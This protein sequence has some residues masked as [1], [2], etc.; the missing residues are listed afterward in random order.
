[1]HRQTINRREAMKRLFVW[2]A[3]A[4]VGGNLLAACDPAVLPTACGPSYDD[5]AIGWGPSVVAP[6][7]YGYADYNP[8]VGAPANMRVYYPSLDGAVQCAPFLAG[9]GHFPLVLFLHGH[10]PSESY[11]YTKWSDLPIVLARSGFIV[12]IPDLTGI[13]NPWELSNPLYALINNVIDWMRSTWSHREFMMEAP[14]LGIVGHSWGTLLG[15]QLALTLPATAYVSL[16]GGWSDWAPLSS[17]P[18]HSL[19]I[20]KLLVWGTADV[21][22]QM[23]EENWAALP[24]PKHRLVFTEGE[25]WDYL[26]PSLTSCD[27]A[28][29]PCDLVETLTADLTALFLSKHMPPEAAGILPGFIPDNLMPPDVSLTHEQMFFAG[30]HLTSFDRVRSRPGCS[31]TLTW[32]TSHMGHKRGIRH[33]FA[34]ESIPD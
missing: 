2:L 20:P 31:A 8:S 15:A 33:A 14:A 1:M 6:V 7:F 34:R 12:A 17:W 9:P 3:G 32:A 13:S 25:H 21:L 24:A 29:G 23:P 11:H 30:Q 19:S 10:C 28:T 22:A 18:G 27:T 26:P 16:G 4:A 5:A